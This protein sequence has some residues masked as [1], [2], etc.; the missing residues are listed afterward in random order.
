VRG[1]ERSLPIYEVEEQI[2]VFM[3]GG[4]KEIVLTGI[5]LS[6]FGRD[7]PGDINLLT[8]IRRLKQTPWPAR[9]RL[10]SMEPQDLSSQV[11]DELAQWPN[12]CPHFHIPLQSGSAAV[13][14]AMERNYRPGDFE[15]LIRQIFARFPGAAIG[16]DVMV[17]FPTESPADF[18]ETRE[19]LDRLPVS[20]LHVFPY[21]ARPNTPAARLQPVATSTEVQERAKNLRALG[22]QK[23]LSFYQG[24]IGRVAEVLVEGE[25]AGNSGWVTGLSDNYLRVQLRGDQHAANQVIQV[26]LQK[27]AGQAL[28]AEKVR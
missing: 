21:S 19:L 24:Q 7:L 4:Y 16:L 1:P 2:Q 22:W 13:L 10:S 26:K 15:N 3:A 18:R 28:V 23:K 5:N 6:R 25:A 20:Y 11:L 12:F 8:L 14:T 9:F 27:I 17:G